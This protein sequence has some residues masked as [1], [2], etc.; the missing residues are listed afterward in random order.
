[1]LDRIIYGSFRKAVI[2][3]CSILAAPMIRGGIWLHDC[4][5]VA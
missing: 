4:K 5:R 3:L 2:I 1:M